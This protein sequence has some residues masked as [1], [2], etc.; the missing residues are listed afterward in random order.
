MKEAPVN[1]TAEEVRATL[2]N[3]KSQFRRVIKP[4]PEF[5][6]HGDGT[7]SDWVVEW[8]HPRSGCLIAEWSEGQVAPQAMLDCCP[9]GKP[10][11]K[12]WVRESFVEL[13]AVSPASD[14]PNEWGNRPYRR[15][16][17]PTSHKRADGSTA[18]H[19]DGLD[20]AWAADGHVEFC[21]GDGFTGESA[22]RDDMPRWKSSMH[23]SRAF[24]RLTLE[25]TDV[26]VQRLQEIG[27]NDCIAEG[28]HPIGP[29]HDPA[30]PRSEFHV[31]WNKLNVKRGYSWESNPW[32]WVVSYSVLPVSNLNGDH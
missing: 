30:I 28:I 11:E 2:E 15:I 14:E 23:M 24:S 6:D 25:I 9:F 3:R 13:L 21:D 4:Q 10:G 1:F 18:W 16:E 20:I 8:C 22:D 32:V 19:Y 27:F 26:R 17:E 7:N 29:E 5:Q 31:R 12:L